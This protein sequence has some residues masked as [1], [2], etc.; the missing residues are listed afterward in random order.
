ML[1]ENT[2]D[3]ALESD[4]KVFKEN[5]WH[6]SISQIEELGLDEFWKRESDL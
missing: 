1:R 4:R 2:P 5:G 3:R 6:I